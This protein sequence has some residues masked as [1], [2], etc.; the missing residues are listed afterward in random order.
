MPSHPAPFQSG[1][2]VPQA[3]VADPPRVLAKCSDRR[4]EGKPSK[5]EGPTS[6]EAREGQKTGQLL[7]RR[8][9]RGGGQ[10]PRWGPLQREQGAAAHA[11]P[12][13]VGAQHSA[14]PH[15]LST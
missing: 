8:E 14:N 11:G 5:L 3:P 6:V 2:Q 7:P 4:G 15:V 13:Q 10:E 1:D 12:T 9:P